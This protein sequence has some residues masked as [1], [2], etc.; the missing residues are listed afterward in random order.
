MGLRLSG[1]LPAR[2]S[3]RMFVRRERIRAMPSPH[4][5]T[6]ATREDSAHPLLNVG[7]DSLPSPDERPGVRGPPVVEIRRPGQLP[8]GGQVLRDLRVG[9]NVLART[10]RCASRT[11][12]GV[13]L[14]PAALRASRDALHGGAH[15]RV[16]NAGGVWYGQ[17]VHHESGL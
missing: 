13:G 8:V 15:V 16:E 10:S 9:H 3:G 17:I 2:V 4:R 12:T 7:A 5:A 11:D 14:R 6:R 1:A